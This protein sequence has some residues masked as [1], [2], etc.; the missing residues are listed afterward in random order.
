MRFCRALSCGY[1]LAFA[2]SHMHS[3]VSMCIYCIYL[4]LWSMQPPP[5]LPAMNT[6]H[7]HPVRPCGVSLRLALRLLLL[8]LS[9]LVVACQCC[10][11]LLT[12]GFMFQQCHTHKHT[13]TRSKVLPI[14]ILIFMAN[15]FTSFAL[16]GHF[17]FCFSFCCW[18]FSCIKG[19]KINAINLC[20]TPGEL[21]AGSAIVKKV[22]A[23]FA[24]HYLRIFRNF[25]TTIQS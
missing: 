18:Y 7:P 6:L 25:C 10:W 23:I 17:L 14:N 5:P 1:S 2:L 24:R 11:P 19:F 8:L 13:H 3:Y 9:T 20:Q 15:K 21:Y 22:K 16:R 4:T 12:E